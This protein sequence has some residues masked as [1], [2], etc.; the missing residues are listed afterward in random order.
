MTNGVL[1]AL[2][3]SLGCV[4]VFIAGIIAMVR[5][6]RPTFEIVALVA[7]AILGLILIVFSRLM[8]S[9]P[10]TLWPGVPA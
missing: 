9:D 1:S 7:L 5:P 8:L 4:L 2:L 6:S 10:A 3:V